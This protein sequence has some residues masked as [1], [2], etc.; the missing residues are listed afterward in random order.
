MAG[1]VM[2]LP[3]WVVFHCSRKWTAFVTEMNPTVVLG[4]SL[5]IGGAAAM[6]AAGTI[7]AKISTKNDK[8]RRLGTAK[9]LLWEKWGLSISRPLECNSLS[10]AANFCQI[11][12]VN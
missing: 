12:F 9:L 5:S 11:E 8:G 3:S 10:V 4:N 1:S 6:S 2:S 7:T